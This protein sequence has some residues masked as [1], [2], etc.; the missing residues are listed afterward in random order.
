MV[1]GAGCPVNYGSESANWPPQ[2]EGYQLINVDDQ[3]C[4]A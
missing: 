2:G 4:G 3:Q 1:P